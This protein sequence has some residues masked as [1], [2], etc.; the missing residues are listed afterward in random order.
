MEDLDTVELKTKATASTEN[1]NKQDYA[2]KNPFQI[3]QQ[4]QLSSSEKDSFPAAAASVLITSIAA[5]AEPVQVASVNKNTQL[6][7]AG[8]SVSPNNPTSFVDV[9]SR[10]SVQQYQRKNPEKNRVPF[11]ISFS[12]DDSSSE[13]EESKKGK[14]LET[15]S[16]TKGMDVA[17]RPPIITLA[18]SQNLR[19]KTTNNTKVIPRKVPLSRTFVSS[20]TKINGPASRIGG[21][22]PV[23]QR[24]RVTNFNTLNKIKAGKGQNIHLNSSK[25]QDLR[26]LIAIRE[27]ELKL[28]A[29]QQNKE[30]ISDS[31]KDYNVVNLS[32][33]TA[34]ICQENSAE[35]LQ[36]EQKEPEKKRLKVTE[37]HT[38][39]LD[40]DGRQDMPGV[41]AVLASEK[42]VSECFDQQR[43]DDR[44][45]CDKE[46][47]GATRGQKQ[48]ENR[49]IVSSVNLSNG[50]NKGT[51]STQCNS[52]KVG[53]SSVSNR[54][55]RTS[56][57][58]S[59]GQS[60]VGAVFTFSFLW[61]SE[62]SVFKTPEL[63]HHHELN[64]LH[65]PSSLPNSSVANKHPRRSHTTKSRGLQ[66]G[67][68]DKAVNPMSDHTYQAFSVHVPDSN[69]EASYVCSDLSKV[70]VFIRLLRMLFD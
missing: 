16:N 49:G 59:R 12:D 42:A 13:S 17:R 3:R 66:V 34:R 7:K 47:P 32:N 14:E 70:A 60:Y 28:K 10:T 54:T 30:T 19:Q 40:S 35:F 22:L 46:I 68:A 33:D 36:F 41:E 27:N 26:Q 55:A 52:I 65:T 39:P 58:K 1:P 18:K 5:P 45:Y 44:S 21:P 51:G 56:P 37:P 25:L 57:Q 69:L 53:G 29:T 20:M 38:S 4:G 23:E 48:E 67:S 2:A 64:H 15:K 62:K 24:S 43:V 9:H 8:I 61:P 50:M 6:V 11:V 31:F 63:R